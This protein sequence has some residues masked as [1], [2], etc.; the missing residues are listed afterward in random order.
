[1]V[2]ARI[3]LHLLAKLCSVHSL[4][5]QVGDHGIRD[6]GRYLRPRL[7]AACRYL[8]IIYTLKFVFQIRPHLT[9]VVYKHD[10]SLRSPVLLRLLLHLRSESHILPAGRM[11]LELRVR[12]GVE[13]L[14]IGRLRELLGTQMAASD[15]DPD[16]ER[17]T[18]VGVV[19]ADL[20][21]VK[22]HKHLGKV[23]TYT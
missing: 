9:V 7:L 10:S 12:L 21:V 15:R 14:M 16:T 5:H 3:L 19:G 11:F 18:L 13:V 22:L 2:G 6:G 20:A 1:M 17:H 23:Q 8:Y 4:H